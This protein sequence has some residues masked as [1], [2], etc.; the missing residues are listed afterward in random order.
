[1]SVMYST[2]IIRLIKNLRLLLKVN[3]PKLSYGIFDVIYRTIDKRLA[4]RN[5]AE[6]QS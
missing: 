4:Y 2:G 3:F 6:A 5:A 1:M